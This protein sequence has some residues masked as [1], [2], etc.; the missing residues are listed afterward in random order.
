MRSRNDLHLIRNDQEER[1]REEEEGSFFNIFLVVSEGVQYQEEREEM[2][3]QAGEAG[4]DKKTAIPAPTPA[5][6]IEEATQ[7]LDLVFSSDLTLYSFLSYLD[8][9]LSPDLDLILLS[10]LQT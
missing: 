2:E 6:R 4:G 10:L 3:D 8:L 7:F 1:R 5:R 9:I